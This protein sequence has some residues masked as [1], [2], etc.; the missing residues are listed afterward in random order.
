MQEPIGQ[1]EVNDIGQEPILYQ[2]AKPIP[3]KPK[4]VWKWIGG[5][6]YLHIPTLEIYQGSYLLELILNRE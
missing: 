6:S 4:K 3:E 2:E 5:D 1:E